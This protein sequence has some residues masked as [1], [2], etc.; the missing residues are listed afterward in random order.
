MTIFQFQNKSVISWIC[1][2]SKNQQTQTMNLDIGTLELRNLLGPDRSKMTLRTGAARTPSA[3]DLVAEVVDGRLQLPAWVVKNHRKNDC[4]LLVH[5]HYDLDNVE[6]PKGVRRAIQQVRAFLTVT[7][8]SSTPIQG[9]LC[10]ASLASAH[11]CLNPNNHSNYTNFVV[12]IRDDQGEIVPRAYND[13]LPKKGGAGFHNTAIPF[14]DEFYTSLDKRLGRLHEYRSSQKSSSPIVKKPRKNKKKDNSTDLRA[15]PDLTIQQYDE[16]AH[17]EHIHPPPPQDKAIKKPRKKRVPKDV[18]PTP[19]PPPKPAAAFSETQYDQLFSSVAPIKRKPGRPKKS[20][21]VPML[22]I[23]DDEPLYILPPGNAESFAQQQSDQVNQQP[24]IPFVFPSPRHI[25][26]SDEPHLNLTKEQ[27][28][29][30]ISQTQAANV[31]TPQEQQ[32]FVLELA[33]SQIDNPNLTD[34]DP[35][36]FTGLPADFLSGVLPQQAHQE[37]APAE[38]PPS[39]NQEE[40]HEGNANNTSKGIV[41]EDALDC[42]PDMNAATDCPATPEID[43]IPST[44]CFA[45]DSTANDCPATPTLDNLDLVPADQD[46]DLAAKPKA[47][48]TRGRPS[49]KASAPKRVKA[50][51]PEE[52]PEEAIEPKEQVPKLRGRKPKAKGLPKKDSTTNAPKR[53]K[54]AK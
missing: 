8:G 4:P 24:D 10:F 33:P 21:A 31:D 22:N 49:T 52:H 6:K 15:P 42:Q 51:P 41:L 2:Q 20:E 18:S 23:T 3:E 1:E 5:Y 16:S 48:K 17:S 26:F 11:S 13:F 9:E 29:S 43:M 34:D 32:Q 39:T 12:Y 45:Q 36:D 28:L 27:V 53:R 50:T 46:A 14:S 40:L 38:Q 44:Q 7:N 19:P 47:K 30:H 25:Q 37:D 54:T 35:I